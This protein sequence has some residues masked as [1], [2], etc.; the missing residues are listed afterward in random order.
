[1]I[2]SDTL[3]YRMLFN[4]AENSIRYNRPNGTVR[5][6]ITDEKNRLVIRV[7]D[8][9]AAYRR[10]TEKAF[11]SHFSG[12]INPEAEK[13]AVWDWDFRWCGRSSHC[14]AVRFG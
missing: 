2:G 6:A 7:A 5:I 9:A 13:T 1:M 12:W 4:L 8:T 14:T 10:N 11:F 3:I